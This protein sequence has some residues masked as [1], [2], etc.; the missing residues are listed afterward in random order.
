MHS[1]SET[2]YGIGELSRI[3]GLT[4]KA[5][6]FYSDRG[7][8]P[9]TGRSPAGYRL[10]GPDALARLHLVRTLRDLGVDLSSVRSVL[11]RETSLP[12]VAQAHVDALDVQIRTL[13]LRRAVLHAVARR[14]PTHL[15]I[16]FMHRLAALSQAQHR[17][18]LA[19]FV[20]DTFQGVRSNP[21][22]AGLM[23]SAVPQ[24]PDDP[25]PEQVEAWLELTELCGDPD[26]RAALRQ[27]AQE[28]AQTP[29][30]HDTM[31][32]HNALDEAMRARID[33]AGSAGILP[34]ATR[35]ASVADT[36]AGL[37]CHAFHDAGD[38][39]LRRWLL[40]RL[41]PATDPY[42]ERYWQLVATVNGWPPS[43][44]LAPVY[45]WFTTYGRRRATA[46]ASTS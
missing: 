11:D 7:I 17:R 24:L 30:V 26:F 10:Y 22:F 41:Q 35:T 13:R 42:C 8:V 12:D 5:I 2:L 16:D 14:D 19:D 40:A 28:Q 15:E 44:T 45:T 34:T 21:E 9:P 18:L 23:R 43:P 29:T 1:D 38:D 36:L 3:T 6:R 27:T 46:T 39:D 32:A 4:V 25:T 20:D 33:E 37:Y 31:D